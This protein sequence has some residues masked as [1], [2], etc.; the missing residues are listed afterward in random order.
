MSQLNPSGFDVIDGFGN[1]NLEFQ[2][3]M[4]GE[5][6]GLAYFHIPLREYAI[7]DSSSFTGVKQ[8]EDEL[9]LFR[10]HLLLCWGGGFLVS[11]LLGGW[12][13]SRRARVV[14]ASLEK[15]SHGDWGAVKS[16]KTWKRLDDKNLTAID[17]Q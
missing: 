5:A 9:K 16:I 7:L 8:E 1:Y 4:E 6:P 10:I 15:G 12:L 13:G 3:C 2:S 14:V 17:G 11:C